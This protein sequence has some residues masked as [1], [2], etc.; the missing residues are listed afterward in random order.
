MSPLQAV[1]P[2]CVRLENDMQVILC[3]NNLI[4][5]SIYLLRP[6]SLYLDRWKKECVALTVLPQLGG[7]I[8]KTYFENRIPVFHS[9]EEAKEQFPDAQVL[10]ITAGRAMELAAQYSAQYK[11]QVHISQVYALMLGT[12]VNSVIPPTDWLKPRFPT[13]RGRVIIG[14]FSAS[15][16]RHSGEKPNK[17]IDDWKWEHIVRFL[18]RHGFDE[19]LCIGSGVDMLEKVSLPLTA[20]RSTSDLGELQEL[21][22]SAQLVICIEGGVGHLASLFNVPTIILWPEVVNMEFIAP[23]WAPLTKYFLI[24][25]PN[26]MPP[27]AL[28][29]GLKKLIRKML[30]EEPEM[31][32]AQK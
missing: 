21:F 16:S 25:D 4:G 18:R 6:V 29:Y 30:E 20:Y 10:Q 24:G 28:L 1:L 14:P 8:V 27:A 7:K 9:I 15:C 26:E 2:F 11:K 12:P 23:A 17:T 31:E 5:D 3:C 22:Q 32:T 13:V 19:V